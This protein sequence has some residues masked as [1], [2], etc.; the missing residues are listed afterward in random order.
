MRSVCLSPPSPDK[1]ALNG[2]QAPFPFRVPL[3]FGVLG[4]YREAF[5]GRAGLSRAMEAEGLWVEPPMDA[6]DLM[7]NIVG[8]TIWIFREFGLV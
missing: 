3:G 1:E 7:A 8:I 5:A 6:W 4:A 2:P